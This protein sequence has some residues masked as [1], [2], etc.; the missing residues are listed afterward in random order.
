MEYESYVKEESNITVV[1]DQSK[2]KNKVAIY[3]YE[4]HK[5]YCMPWG[6][7]N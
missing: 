2:Q 6:I 1:I 7:G 3:E 5:G 4:G